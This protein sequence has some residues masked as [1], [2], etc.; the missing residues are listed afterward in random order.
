MSIERN[1]GETIDQVSVGITRHVR[2]GQVEA[3]EAWLGE[4]Q[5]VV[6]GFDGYAGM[7]VVRPSGSDSRTYVMILRFDS[8]QQYNA[9]HQ[10]QARDEI[11]ERSTAM[12][13]GDP[14]F[15]EAHG[16]DAWFT[17]PTPM[18]HHPARYKTATLTVVGLY[19]LI[20]LVGALVAATTG[21]PVPLGTLVTVTIVAAIAT[22]WVMPWITR[23][24]RHWLFPQ[25]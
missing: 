7:N 6:S 9:W 8:Y 1:T 2:S 23:V 10:S 25:P 17:P 19:P 22:Y 15:E 20:L 12:T 16:L 5:T 21:L 3:F 11:V 18:V 13:T 14:S 4:I 24:A